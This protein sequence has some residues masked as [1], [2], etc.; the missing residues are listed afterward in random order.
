MRGLWRRNKGSG[1]NLVHTEPVTLTWRI[2][3]GS[4]PYSCNS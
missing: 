3:A 2:T 4:M 1:M